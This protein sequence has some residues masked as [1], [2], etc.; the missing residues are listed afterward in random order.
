MCE[1]YV[2]P[3]LFFMVCHPYIDVHFLKCDSAPGV[4]QQ[5]RLVIQLI[6]GGLR[7]GLM[8]TSA[9]IIYHYLIA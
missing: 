5:L 9:I 3:F 4:D 8:F 7:S 1:V 2:I 6:P